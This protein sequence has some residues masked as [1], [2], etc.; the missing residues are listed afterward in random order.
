MNTEER[1]C[2]FAVQVV[3]SRKIIGGGGGL[4]Y[5]QQVFSLSTWLD[6]EA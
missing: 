1:N 2:K 5:R 3:S 4:S 6:L